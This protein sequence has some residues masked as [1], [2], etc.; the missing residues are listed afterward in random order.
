[1]AGQHRRR[2]KR[3]KLVLVL[4]AAGLALAAA[5]TI[6]RGDSGTEASTGWYVTVYYTAVESHHDEDPVPVTGCL[7]LDCERGDDPLGSYPEDFVKAVEDEGTGRIVSGRHAG[8]YLNWSHDTGFWLD[9]APRDSHGRPLE[10]FVSA[11]ADPAVLG[12]GRELRITG[13]GTAE[14]G[15]AIDAGV[16]DRL[17]SASWRIMDEFTP[18]LGGDRHI[19][20]YLG[21][22]TGPD[23]TSDPLYSSLH[24]AT[25][26]LGKPTP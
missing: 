19:D 14:D 3:N 16:C 22:E 11:A 8:R 24:N 2:P 10:P 4:A 1:M 5:S 12:D 23:F 18:G 6:D 20:V 13:C 21:E 9:N 7:V 15:T 17:R 26:E 25:L